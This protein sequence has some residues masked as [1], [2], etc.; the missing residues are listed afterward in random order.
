MIHPL[1]IPN[2]QII[3]VN[4]IGVEHVYAGDQWYH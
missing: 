3:Q 4:E 2:A 1:I